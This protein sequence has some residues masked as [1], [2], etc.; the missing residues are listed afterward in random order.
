VRRRQLL[1]DIS[2]ELRTPTTAI[3]GESEVTLRGGNRTVGEYREALGRIVDISRQLG[4]VINDLLAMARTDM[5]TFS[6]VREP[7][8]LKQ[9][10]LDALSQAAAL[11]GEHDV[12][13]TAEGSLPT[14]LTV[15][16]DAQR[17]TQLMLLL[18]DNAIRYSH[19]GGV[20]CWRVDVLDDLV[21]LHVEDHGI[22][23]PSDE[24]PQ[25]FER[26]FR[27]L[28]AR[29]HRAS[30]SGLGLPIARALALA[31]GGTLDIVSTLNESEEGGRTCA[32]L[33]L[34]LWHDP[35]NPADTSLASLSTDIHP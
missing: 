2:H 33:R 9:P 3:R 25:I 20:V 31:H 19:Q 26:H 7:V 10:L 27:G 22:G 12:R 4:S 11:A 8:V 17:L 14:G 13:L 23:I 30:G 5:E 24:L 28:E 35:V 1:A 6:L 16:G 34:P 15:F 32:T 29:R 21:A 18:L